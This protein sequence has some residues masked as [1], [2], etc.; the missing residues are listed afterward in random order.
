MRV[1]Q[2]S[3][4]SVRLLRVGE[5]IRHAISAILQRGEVQDADLAGVSVTVTEVRVSPDLRN[6]SVFVMPL[7]GD[8]DGV[9]IPALNRHSGF[10]RGQLSGKVHM[11]YL[12]R[13]RFIADE[14]FDEASHIESLLADPKVARD[15]QDDSPDGA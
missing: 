14:S 3:G 1:K 10:L 9:V 15:L 11:K 13:L 12:P 5:S 4:Q 6:A 7:G 2:S 8:G